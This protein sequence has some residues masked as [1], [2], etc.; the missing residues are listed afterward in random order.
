MRV[1]MRV[2]PSSDNTVHFNHDNLHI[3]STKEELV[4][5]V[6]SASED[7]RKVRVIGSGHSWSQV[8]QSEDILIS[9]HN[10]AGVVS[11]DVQEKTVTVKAGTK[12]KDVTWALEEYGLAMQNLGS[13]SE[14]TAAGA[15]ST[16]WFQIPIMS[17][18]PSRWNVLLRLLWLYRYQCYVL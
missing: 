6:K 17:Y 11:V 2:F 12:L 5:L 1:V 16:G 4:Q 9:L 3:P 8:A 18:F 13:I 7:V 15:I 10:Y 14:Q